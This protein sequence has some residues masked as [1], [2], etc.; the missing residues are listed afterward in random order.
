M[1]TQVLVRGQYALYTLA[2]QTPVHL[3]MTT[4][5]EDAVEELQDVLDQLGACVRSPARPA[6]A[7][8]FLEVA[9]AN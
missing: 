6:T 9:S 8:V 1:T 2:I 5:G 3:L 7:T 4:E